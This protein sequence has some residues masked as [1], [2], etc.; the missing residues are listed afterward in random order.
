MIVAH[1]YNFKFECIKTFIT[2]LR[3]EPFLVDNDLS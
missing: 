1:Y 2:E 3:S